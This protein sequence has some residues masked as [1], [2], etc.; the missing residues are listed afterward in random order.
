MKNN[1]VISPMA[2]LQVESGIFPFVKGIS[3][4]I[5]TMFHDP[6]KRIIIGLVCFFILRDK[7]VETARYHFLNNQGVHLLVQEIEDPEPVLC[8]H[9][10]CI[11]K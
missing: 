8:R 3:K 11:N 5:T 7:G 2:I 1:L 9:S 6:F 4:L 10:Y